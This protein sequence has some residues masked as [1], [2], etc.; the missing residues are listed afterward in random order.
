MALIKIAGK[1]VEI[2]PP[3]IGMLKKATQFVK[4]RPVREAIKLTEGMP[5]AASVAILKDAYAEQRSDKRSNEQVW[6]AIQKDQDL[7]AIVHLFWL[8]LAPSGVTK[9]E[10]EA[11]GQDEMQLLM[12][13]VTKDMP[14]ED[15]NNSG[16][17]QGS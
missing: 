8:M 3:T 15:K 10:V 4:E 7:D 14:K 12:D 6:E 9:E 17:V 5:E 1:A 2:K 13:E 16:N 11:M